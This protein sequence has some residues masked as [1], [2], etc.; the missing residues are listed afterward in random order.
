MHE[1]GTPPIALPEQAAVSR[2][3]NLDP[4]CSVCNVLGGRYELM[5]GARR[6]PS[7]AHDKTIPRPSVA[8]PLPPQLWGVLAIAAVLLVILIGLRRTAGIPAAVHWR[9]RKLWILS[10]LGALVCIMTTDD[11]VATIPSC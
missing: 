2:A 11:S 4:V 7:P 8:P 5:A 3:E 9:G 10:V 6:W 1:R